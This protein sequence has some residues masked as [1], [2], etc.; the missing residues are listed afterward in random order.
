MNTPDPYARLRAEL[1]G[2]QRPGPVRVVEVVGFDGGDVIVRAGEDGAPG[3]I[4]AGEV[5]MR[6]GGSAREVFEAG[7]LVEA[8]EFGVREQDGALLLSARACEIPAL[9]AFLAGLEPGQRVTGTVAS[10]RPF[11]AFVHVDGEPEGRCTGLIQI[12]ELSW[13]PVS[14]PCEVVEAGR[15]ITAEV[16]VAEPR[17][18]QVSLSLKAVAGDGQDGP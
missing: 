4:P 6:P 16:I 11:G 1:A 10:V 14:H 12:P 3:R 9:R 7:Q 15:R 18:G 8:E 5:S 13:S 2:R 17:T